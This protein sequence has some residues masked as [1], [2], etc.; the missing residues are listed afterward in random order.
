M[1]LKQELNVPLI[2]EVL[3]DSRSDRLSVR[4]VQA[5]W[6]IRGSDGETMWQLAQRAYRD[7]K[8]VRNCGVKTRTEIEAWLKRDFK[9]SMLPAVKPGRELRTVLHRLVMAAAACV[10]LAGCGFSPM[11]EGEPNCGSPHAI[12][13]TERGLCDGSIQV[14]CT[15]DDRFTLECIDGLWTYGHE[16]CARGLGVSL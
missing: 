4:A 12:H 14:A 13:A 8:R 11:Y 10:A 5:L 6:E 2:K 16:S 1:G 7:L 15:C 3:C 9:L